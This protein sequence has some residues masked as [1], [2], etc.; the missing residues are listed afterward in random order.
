MSVSPSRDSAVS[1]WRSLCLLVG[2]SAA[3]V[4]AASC[5]TASIPTK[6][7]QASTPTPLRVTVFPY[8]SFAPLYIANAE[9]YFGQQGLDVELVP[10]TGNSE[11]LP[12]LLAG[13][14]DV[15]SIFTV[16]LLNAA[17]GG[18][19]VRVVANKGLLA[20]DRCTADGFVVRT[21]LAEEMANPAPEQLKK[22]VY[23]VDPTWLDSY[24]LDKLL[25]TRGLRLDDVNT[26]YIPNPAARMDALANGSLDVAFF[27]EPW[28]SRIRESGA[29]QLWVGASEVAPSYSL[30][31]LTFGPNLLKSSDPDV[32]VRFLRAYLQGVARLNEGKTARNVE[33]LAQ[34][35][36]LDPDL[37]QSVCW[38]SFDPLGHVDAAGISGYSAWSAERGLSD[39]PLAPEEFW[40]PFYV[41]AAATAG[42]STHEKP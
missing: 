35:T 42:A 41:D 3:L 19:N 17:A 21:A 29:G 32:G 12:A 33:I 10:F 11:S 9:G 7:A 37:L 16:G 36:K 6:Q 5:T 31:V 13:Q 25:A 2:W 18:E 24:F 22:L 34:A 30:G 1:F 40:D 26:Q 15:D 4:S 20:P 28:I 23:G 38:P 39:R 27:S 8:L 14:I